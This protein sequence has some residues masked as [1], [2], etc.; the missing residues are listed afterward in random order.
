MP[1]LRLALFKW[2]HFEPR[3]LFARFVGTK[4]PIK[5]VGW[6][7]HTESFLQHNRPSDPHR[8][9]ISFLYV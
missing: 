8:A 9:Q 3:S 4:P 7:W 5:E 1:K 6:V 2:R